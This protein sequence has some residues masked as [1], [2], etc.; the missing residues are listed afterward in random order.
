MKPTKAERAK[1]AWAQARSLE[2]TALGELEALDIAFQ[3]QGEE[4]EKDDEE[5]DDRKAGA[6][7]QN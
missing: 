4:D 6:A 2:M 1:R 7:P 5:S 3:L